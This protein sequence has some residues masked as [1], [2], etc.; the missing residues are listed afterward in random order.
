MTSQVTGIEF[1]SKTRNVYEN[2]LSFAGRGLKLN[3]RDDVKELVDEIRKMKRMQVLRLEGNTISPEAAD[4]LARA[5]E[6]H[7]EL[8][9]FIGNDIFTGRLKDEIPLALR[10]I[11][12]A[13]DKSGAHLVELNMCDNAFG[14]IGLEGLVSFLQSACCYSL[15]EIRMHNNGLGQDGAKKFASALEQCYLNSNKKFAL[16]VFVC[17]RNRLEFEGS[18]A[19]SAVL[20]QL[21]SL[22]ELQMPQNGIRPNG[23][24]FI[25]D[26]CAHNKKLRIINLNDNTFRKP[27]G[28][29]MARVNNLLLL[30][31][32]YIIL[33]MKKNQ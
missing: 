22:E 11:C 6:S 27:G 23:I 30:L 25:A 26:A 16:R 31:L 20:K 2:E 4:E 17:G 21:G 19:L 1:L 13:I 14:P 15:K 24:E 8:E 9:R 28:D 7:P 10:S 12:G 32:F 29:S 33:I 5:L 3:K 18:R